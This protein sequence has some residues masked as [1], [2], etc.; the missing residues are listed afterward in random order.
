MKSDTSMI[1]ADFGNFRKF[2]IFNER[3]IIPRNNYYYA[4]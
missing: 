4:N 1:F 3:K 2:Q